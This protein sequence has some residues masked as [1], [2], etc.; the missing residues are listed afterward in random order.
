MALIRRG[1]RACACATTR[2][3]LRI[4]IS[5]TNFSTRA[6]TQRSH[7]TNTSLLTGMCAITRHE[8]HLRLR[9]TNCMPWCI[10]YVTLRSL[11]HMRV[12]HDASRTTRTTSRHELHSPWCISY[13]TLIR[14]AHMWCAITRHELYVRLCVTNCIRHGALAMWH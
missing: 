8:L 6:H 1:T 9:V 12:C 13:M 3:E 2:H 10:S 7:S 11:A 14:L 4:R 5:V